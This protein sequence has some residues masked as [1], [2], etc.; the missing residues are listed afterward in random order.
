MT[1]PTRLITAEQFSERDERDDG[2]REELVA[3]VIEV[4]PPPEELHGD[5]QFNVAEI[6]RPFVRRHRLGRVRGDV[7]YRV[8]RDP[9]YVPGPDASFLSRERAAQFEKTG[10]YRDTAPDLAIEIVSPSDRAERVQ[11]KVQWYLGAGAQRVWLLYPAT[12]SLTVHRDDGNAHTYTGN[13]V[14][15]SDDA[16][17]SVDGFEARVSD[18]FAELD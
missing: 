15:T 2:C 10:T 13:D 14:I 7:G 3:G 18:F 1:A 16:G 12:A 8:R 17:F 6:L 5:I 9:D 4:A 11:E